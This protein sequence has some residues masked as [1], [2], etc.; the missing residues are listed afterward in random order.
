MSWK[1]CK[2]SLQIVTYDISNGAIFADLKCLQGHSAPASLFV[3]NFSCTCATVYMSTD[4]RCHAVLLQQLSFLSQ[5]S[6]IQTTRYRTTSSLHAE[7]HQQQI[8]SQTYAISVANISK[9]LTI[10][11]NTDSVR[12]TSAPSI[13]QIISLSKM[14]RTRISSAKTAANRILIS[15]VL[16][17]MST[18]DEI[19]ERC[20]LL[21]V[22]LRIN[23]NIGSKRK[24]LL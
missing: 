10:N 5:R 19:L 21:A 13:L 4:F 17:T 8:C 24:M 16:T 1:W 22:D 2:I 7:W 23:S 20:Q 15:E 9:I 14:T 11:N 6:W 18:Y 12:N 3:C